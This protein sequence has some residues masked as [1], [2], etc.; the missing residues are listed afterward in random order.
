MKG[1]DLRAR[2]REQAADTD[3]ETPEAARD[4][5]RKWRIESQLQVEL[6]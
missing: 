3:R 1:T 2:T 4:R 5:I 6:D